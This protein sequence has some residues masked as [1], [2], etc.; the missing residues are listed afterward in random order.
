MFIGE[1]SA[2]PPSGM[3]T[4]LVLEPRLAAE[5]GPDDLCSDDGST[6][7]RIAVRCIS[8][9]SGK[10]TKIVVARDSAGLRVM[11]DEKQ[12]LWKPPDGSRRCYELH[13]L[14]TR[15]LE[16]LR[17]TW[18]LDEP[19]CARDSSRTSMKVTLKLDAER[20]LKVDVPGSPTCYPNA[21]VT[22]LG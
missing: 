16:P 6:A 11:E 5:Y 14:E 1:E 18:M 8:G 2:K 12:T 9:S 22:L 21:K 17:K 3:V 13:G 19:K 7:D 15:D 10:T 20:D 4:D